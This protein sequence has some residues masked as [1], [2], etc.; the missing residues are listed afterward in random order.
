MPSIN[1]TTVLKGPALVTYGG[2]SFWSKGDITVTPVFER[3]PI[4]TAHFGEVTER[5]SNRKFT[6]AFEPSGR[7]TSGLAAVMWAVAAKNPGDSLLGGT[8]AA[9]VVHGRDGVK[10]TFHNA[11]ITGAPSLRLSTGTTISGQMTFT[12]IVANSTD[13]TN[14][15]AYYTIASQAYPGD[16]GFAV[17]DIYT[18]PYVA[19]WGVSAPWANFVTDAGWEVGFEMNVREEKADGIG[20]YDLVLENLKVTAK[21][22]PVGPTMA[23]IMTALKTGEALG[24][25]LSGD[26]DLVIASTVVGA[27]EVTISRAAMIESGFAFGSQPKRIGPTTWQATRLITAGVAQPLFSV[28]VA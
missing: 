17:A 18:T 25:D 8:D 9:L 27:P 11:A 2:Q 5:H 20:T 10:I 1:R 7:F 14:A 19:N 12:A 16:A 13:P 15:A 6:I 28:A 24:T 22:A 3:F 4:S 26:D 23:Q 21:A